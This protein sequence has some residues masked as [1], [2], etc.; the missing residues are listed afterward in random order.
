M[1]TQIDKCLCKRLI[2][3]TSG[4]LCVFCSQNILFSWISNLKHT[5]SSAFFNTNSM[6]GNDII[7]RSVQRMKVWV[8]EP[9]GT[10]IIPLTFDNSS[11]QFSHL[12]YLPKFWGSLQEF[13]FYILNQ[14][15]IWLLKCW[16]SENLLVTVA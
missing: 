9:H 10:L 1:L 7:V 16:I 5:H 15:L 8:H 13:H 6:T 12:D 11:V 3:Q 2:K 14:K 4:S